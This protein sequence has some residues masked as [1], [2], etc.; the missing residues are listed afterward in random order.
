MNFWLVIFLLFFSMPHRN[1][2]ERA[3]Y[4]RAHHERNKEKNSAK[5]ANNYKKRNVRA[6][7]L[8]AEAKQKLGGKCAECGLDDERV[9]QFNHKVPRN[10]SGHKITTLARNVRI[11]EVSLF[12]E[13]VAECNLLCAN[14]HAL[15]TQQ[16]Y[17]D[18]KL[19]TTKKRRDVP[20]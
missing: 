16:Q 5:S 11:A 3:A 15:E 8:I 14:C 20:L 1:P 12:W 13:A 17:A 19:N 18:G 2:E 4:F 7:K 10:G 9:L 6:L